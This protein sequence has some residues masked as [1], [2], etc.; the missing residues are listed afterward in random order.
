M[1]ITYDTKSSKPK[2]SKVKFDNDGKSERNGRVK[3][4]DNKIGGNKVE[5]KE[6]IDN[7]VAKKKNYQKTSKKQKVFWTFLLSE[8]R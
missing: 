2:K 7:K 5:D 4:Y 6:I 1:L 8:L 3:V